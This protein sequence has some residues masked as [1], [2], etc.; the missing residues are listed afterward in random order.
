LAWFVRDLLFPS[1]LIWVSISSTVERNSL[2][3]LSE[4]TNQTENQAELLQAVF[5]LQRGFYDNI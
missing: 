5:D 1:V 2:I 3:D 4:R